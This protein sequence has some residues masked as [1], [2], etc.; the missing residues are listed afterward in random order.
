MSEQI[1]GYT[2]GQPAGAPAG[3]YPDPE[4]P[5]RMRWWDGWAW[6]AAQEPAGRIDVPTGTVWIWLNILLPLVS[7]PLLFLMDTRGLMEASFTSA[8]VGDSRAMTS[9]YAS[10]FGATMLLTL[11][12]LLIGAAGVLFAWL[13]WRELRRRGIPRPFAWPWAFFVFVISNGVYVIG[14]SVVLWRRTGRG[15]G[16]LW[17]WIAVTVVALV[18]G[19]LYTVLVMNQMLE[20]MSAYLPSSSYR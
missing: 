5:A 6:T 11:V 17:G 18:V 7:L 19:S 20:L 4:D 14:R 10:F 12:S 16:P 1:T 13:D 15:L 3:W 9:A 2:P 8:L